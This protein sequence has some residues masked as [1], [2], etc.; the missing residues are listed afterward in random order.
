MEKKR[1]G[2]DHRIH[3]LYISSIKSQ[4]S[5]L[6]S[7]FSCVSQLYITYDTCF[8][9]LS[10]LTWH[11][12]H[13]FVMNSNYLVPP[14]KS[15]LSLPKFKVPESYPATPIATPNME[16]TS[17]MPSLLPPLAKVP[18]TPLPTPQLPYNQSWPKDVNRQQLPSLKHLPL[19]DFHPPQHHQPTQHPEYYPPPQPYYSY[20]Q[21]AVVSQP[22]QPQ[23]YATYHVKQQSHTHHTILNSSREIKRRTKTGCLT[24][25]KRRIKV[26]ISLTG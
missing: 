2:K 15:P 26:C 4:T 10:L 25:R 19:M 1:Y 8:F 12:R 16:N 18:G 24:C 11:S 23:Y 9:S 5:F 22:P 17:Y 7:S 3:K 21:P 13:S 20:Q 14:S 6:F